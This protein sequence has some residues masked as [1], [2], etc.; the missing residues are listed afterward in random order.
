MGHSI[1]SVSL[2][3]TTAKIA[4][5][6]PNFSEFVRTMLLIHADESQ[7]V[8]VVTLE[9]DRVTHFVNLNGRSIHLRGR[10]NPFHK[11]GRCLICWPVGTSIQDQLWDLKKEHS[12]GFDETLGS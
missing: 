7:L 4:G 6:I 12:E 11:N 9:E 2:C 1:K 10:C 3:Q 5:S 8:H